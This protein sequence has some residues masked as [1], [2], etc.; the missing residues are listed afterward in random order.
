MRIRN[1][2]NHE[3]NNLVIR[4]G[5]GELVVVSRPTGDTDH[6]PQDYTPC[7]HCYGWYS[8]LDLWKHVAER[9]VWHKSRN[10]HSLPPPKHGE[11][12]KALPHSSNEKCKDILTAMRANNVKL[13]VTFDG[14]D[15]ISS[16][17]QC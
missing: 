17:F 7:P 4:S 16:D 5:A 1:L 14:L 12:M 3:H 11:L 8:C 9:Y 10:E 2:G 6:Q 15:R 13:T